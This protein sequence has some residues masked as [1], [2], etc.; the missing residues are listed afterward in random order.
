MSNEFFSSKRF[1]NYFRFDLKQLWHQN[2]KVALMLGFLSVICYFIWVAGSLV[3]THSWQAPGLMARCTFFGFGALIL[4]FFQTRTYGYLT[5]RKSGS[6]WLMI[7]ASTF[8]K[9][10]SMMIVTI[11]VLPI[12]Y[13]FSYLTLDGIIALLD[14]TAGQPLLSG[15]SELIQAGN[16]AMSAASEEGVQ[17]NFMALSMPVVFQVIGNL[18][19]FL[20][21]GLCFKK[22]KVAGGIGVLLLVEMLLMPVL[23]L[24]FSKNWRPLLDQYGGGN[25][26]ELITGWVNGVMNIASGLNIVIAVGL[27]IAIYFRIKTLKH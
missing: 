11:L 24:F 13:I 27:A 12:A 6:A 21:C 22:W 20:L 2:G 9:W 14:P 5:E 8:E 23:S 25:D 26:P 3:F 1:W 19:Y 7:P 4:V 10:L 16:K 15:S 17:F 18:L